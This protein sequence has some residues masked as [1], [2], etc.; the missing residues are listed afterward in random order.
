MRSNVEVDVEVVGGSRSDRPS[1]RRHPRE[2]KERIV[3][4]YDALP[5]SDGQRGSLLRREKLA[6]HQISAWRRQF[7]D[8]AAGV[9][10]RRP[11][12]TPGEVELDRL[13]Q[14]NARLEVELQRTRLA[15]EIAGKAVALLELL[16]ERAAP[17]SKPPT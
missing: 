13:R 9:P 5:P 17:G 8:E 6:R 1:K 10:A 15:V 11:K 14:S 4:E 7:A 2:Y 16:S 12:R 3:A